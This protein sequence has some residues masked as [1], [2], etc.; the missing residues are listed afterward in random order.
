MAR[1][2]E[3]G[4]QVSKPFGEMARYDFVVE[5]GARCLRVQVKS[6]MFVDRGGYS[7]S[8]RGCRGP[9]EGDPF[10][11][12]AVYVIPEDLWYI[13]PAGR[14]RMQGSIALYPKLEKSK[15]KR[16]LEAWHLLRG[17]GKVGRIEACA[18][19][20]GGAWRELISMGI[21]EAVK[22]WNKDADRSVRAT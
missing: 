11:F 8:V 2:S 4:L 19:V 21:G 6:T 18:E 5:H 20:R 22:F 14:F 10:D 7:C 3:E 1:A 15:Y 9:Y 13:I 16:Y 12:L 17:E